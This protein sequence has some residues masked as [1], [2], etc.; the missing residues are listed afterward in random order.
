MFRFV[1]RKA[2]SRG[3]MKAI[4]SERPAAH[5]TRTVVSPQDKSFFGGPLRREGVSQQT[6]DA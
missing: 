4:H 3:S 1:S 5:E 6:P 2:L